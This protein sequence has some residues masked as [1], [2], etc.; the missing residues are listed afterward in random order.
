MYTRKDNKALTLK[1][2]KDIL[3]THPDLKINT[4][5]IMSNDEEGNEML[6]LYGIEIK[7]N[8]ITLWPA[9]L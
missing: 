5:I 8:Q 1:D 4:P 9:H 6:S 2:L 7:D 3:A